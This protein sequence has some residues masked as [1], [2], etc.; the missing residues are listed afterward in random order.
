VVTIPHVVVRI[1]TRADN[2]PTDFAHTRRAVDD[3]VEADDDVVGEMTARQRGDVDAADARRT[4]PPSVAQTTEIG[5]RL[6]LRP[7]GGPRVVGLVDTA[8]VESR[9]V[10]RPAGEYAKYQLRDANMT[11][12]TAVWADQ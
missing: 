7:V 1:R 12:G 10:T 8:R 3:A 6:L 2:N 11:R 9:N 4:P 5:E